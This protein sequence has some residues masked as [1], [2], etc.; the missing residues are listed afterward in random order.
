[1]RDKPLVWRS[2]VMPF[3]SEDEMAR[4][5]WT[6]TGCKASV[7]HS[8]RLC[9]RCKKM[10]SAPQAEEAT[11]RGSD[12]APSSPEPSAT[13]RGS[14]SW[15]PESK[16]HASW[17]SGWK[18]GSPAED[19]QTRW[20]RPGGGLGAAHYPTS[21]GAQTQAPQLN[22]A[23]SEAQWNWARILLGL[24]NWH[25][26]RS[27]DGRVYYWDMLRNSVQWKPP[28]FSLEEIGRGGTRSAG[29]LA[30]Q[31]QKAASASPAVPAACGGDLPHNALAPEAA[32]SSKAAASS[33]ALWPPACQRSQRRRVGRGGVMRVGGW[34]PAWCDALV[35][36][37]WLVA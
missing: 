6:C 1:M 10:K 2:R 11:P 27:A 28:V 34:S 13:W 30:K 35:R 22:P 17:W 36:P 31:S 15:W 21:V 4:C 24:C 7:P 32:P 18:S 3:M 14:A 16:A 25:A 9:Y 37:K 8:K 12:I 19:D 26:L 23:A 33:E 5:F 29:A 20:S